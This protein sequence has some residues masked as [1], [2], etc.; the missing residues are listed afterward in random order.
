V[1]TLGLTT[2]SR[3]VLVSEINKVL[4]DFKMSKDPSKYDEYKSLRNDV[5]KAVDRDKVDYYKNNLQRNKNYPKN[6]GKQLNN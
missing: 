6:C 2:R 5:K 1:Q 4:R 3:V